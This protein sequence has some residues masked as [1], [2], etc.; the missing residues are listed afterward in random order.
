MFKDWWWHVEAP[1]LFVISLT[2]CQ[3]LALAD[4]LVS[5][6]RFLL[7]RN[8][9]WAF[10]EPRQPAQSRFNPPTKNIEFFTREYLESLSFLV[11]KLHSNTSYQAFG[12]LK[13][14][15]SYTSWTHIWLN[16]GIE[17]SGQ[18]SC[19]KFCVGAL[20]RSS[21]QAAGIICIEC[22]ARYTI[23]IMSMHVAWSFVMSQI[24]RQAR[25]KDWTE[26]GRFSKG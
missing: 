14:R 7:D 8:Q 24:L 3:N 2:T 18:Y 25:G 4:F 6:S 5:C 20:C 13:L 22:L 23:R 10:R 19:L 21:M 11:S 12:S 15:Y 9:S 16:N 1:P 26:A 17:V